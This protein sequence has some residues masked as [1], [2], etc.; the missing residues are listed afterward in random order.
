MSSSPLIF[1]MAA[2]VAWTAFLYVL[3]TFFRAP[4]A[5][6]IGARPDGTNPWAMLEKRTSANLS[7][8]FEW[9]LLFYV[10]CLLLIG[11]GEAD[12]M[13]VWLAW[14][15]VAG[16][17]AHTFVQVLVPGVRLRGLIFTVNF[18]AVLLMWGRLLLL[19]FTPAS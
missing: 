10:A 7:N 18:V 17:I 9:P 8:Q 1:P 3:L 6:G 4:S 5:W 13:Q 2:H 14:I 19:Q 16:R 15:F 12:P 11:R